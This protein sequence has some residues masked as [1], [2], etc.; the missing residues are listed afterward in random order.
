MMLDRGSQS[1]SS[2]DKGAPAPTIN[3][4]PSIEDRLT[5]TKNH[6]S[7][8]DY[9]RINL[10][11]LILADHTAIVCFGND[12]QLTLFQGVTRP[13]ALSLVPIFFALS[14][15]LV[16]SSLVRS[17][18]LITFVG[19]RVLRIVPALTVDTLFCALVLG[20]LLTDLPLKEYFRSHDFFKYFLNIVGDIHYNLPGV[21]A[22][23][24][25]HA[26]NSQLWTIPY[27][28]KCYAVLTGAA[29]V[30][31][32]R[33]PLLLLV[34]TCIVVLGT[35]IYV[36]YRP[37]E[38]TDAWQLLVPSFLLGVCA[39]S[40]RDKLPW[41]PLL[42]ALSFA[43]MIVLLSQYNALMILAAYPVAYLTVWIG[44]LNPQRGAIIRS[45]DYS[46]PLYLYSFPIQQMLVAVVPGGRIWW[47][48]ILL[49]VPI[50]FIFA[51]LSWHLVEKPAQAGRRYLYGFERWMH[52][53]AQTPQ[54]AVPS[55]S[56]IKA[57]GIPDIAN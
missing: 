23:N 28:L 17:R 15:F 51:A 50:T 4:P 9:L 10:A 6:P 20:V 44:L 45:G 54:V 42:A 24:P 41:S 38:I 53:E 22:R 31:L 19:L 48:N 3:Q 55:P 25:S 39:F 57:K 16:A 29:L 5:I 37:V 18:S 49:A 52:G 32:H 40:Y 27:E 12:M 35:M 56:L 7:G 2:D 1:A 30:G 14:G 26:V 46:Y 21:F 8:F 33:R 13:F 36:T 47:I 34:A 11:L 43:A